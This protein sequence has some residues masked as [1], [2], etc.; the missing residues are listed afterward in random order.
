MIQC[1]ALISGSKLLEVW[2]RAFLYYIFGAGCIK[3]EFKPN[4]STPCFTFAYASIGI[5]AASVLFLP[6]KSRLGHQPS[7]K[8][9]KDMR[10]PY[11]SNFGLSRAM[12]DGKDLKLA[13]YES[14]HDAVSNIELDNYHHP[15]KRGDPVVP[16]RP[17]FDIYS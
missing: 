14:P 9:A 2:C 16:Y 6:A 17:S 12:T 3:S 1:W 13:Y 5:R 8:L 11:L 10:H 15:L 4:E 7:L